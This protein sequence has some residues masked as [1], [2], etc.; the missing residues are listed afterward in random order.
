V[1]LDSIRGKYVGDC[2]NGK[3]EGQGKS[4]GVDSYEGMFKAGLPNGEGKYFWKNG[5]TYSGSWVKGNK[6]GKGV[7]I[8]KTAANTDSTVEGFWKKDKYIGIYEQ[9]FSVLSKSVHVTSIQI[10]KINGSQKQVDIYLDSET[11]KQV[12]SY[13]GANPAPL[14]SDITLIN[15]TYLKLVQNP[16]LGKK[17]FYSLEDVTFPFR[18]L[19][20]V[21]NDLFEIE[22]FEPGKWTVDTRMSF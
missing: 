11:G 1:R 15:G 7:L 8:Y 2:K 19:F 20:R 5:N 14:I 12:V 16:N 17:I 3:A 10:R 22:I 21:D 4:E 18:A 13:A 6:D 9:P